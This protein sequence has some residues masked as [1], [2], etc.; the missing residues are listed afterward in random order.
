LR[1]RHEDRQG[2]VHHPFHHCEDLRDLRLHEEGKVI[3]LRV[4]EHYL[5]QELPELLEYSLFAF[6]LPYYF[7]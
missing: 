2:G 3:E 6:R 5:K 7:L 4:R 1:A